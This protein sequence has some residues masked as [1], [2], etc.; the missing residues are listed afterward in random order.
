MLLHKVDFEASHCNIFLVVCSDD[1]VET[2]IEVIDFYLDCFPGQP[3]LFII[4]LR[5]N[6]FGL[7]LQLQEDVGAD[8]V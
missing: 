5:L 8:C 3:A 1:E 6:S 4:I 2:F 7:A